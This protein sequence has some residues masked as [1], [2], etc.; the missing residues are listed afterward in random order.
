MAKQKVI[1][2][3]TKKQDKLICQDKKAENE[4][5]QLNGLLKEKIDDAEGQ[6]KNIEFLVDEENNDAAQTLQELEKK[7]H[8]QLKIINRG[9]REQRACVKEAINNI[10]DLEQVQKEAI[11]PMI[12]KQLIQSCELIEDNAR[13]VNK[14]LKDFKESKCDANI[15]WYDKGREQLE[16][17]IGLQEPRRH[18][19]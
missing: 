3:L 8:E 19:T 1:V 7:K 4:S 2:E 12:L 10:D 16:H 15:R 5:N 18:A 6:I 17:D 9:K 11:D 14:K 13:L